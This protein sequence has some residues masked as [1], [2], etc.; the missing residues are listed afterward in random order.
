MLNNFI[1][2]FIE[3]IDYL[4]E[5]IKLIL[6][7]IDPEIQRNT[8]EIR[9]R[10]NR[11]L[12]IK[13]FFKNYYVYNNSQIGLDKNN[14]LYIISEDQIKKSFEN[15]CEYSVYAYQEEINNGFITLQNGS[16]VGIVGTAVSKDKKIINIKNISCLNIR[17]PKN[18]FNVADEL[19]TKTMSKGLSSLLICGAP[20][21]GK[22]TLLKD[23]IRQI[24]LG[25]LGYLYNISVIDERGELFGNQ[26]KN[27]FQNK[28]ENNFDIFDRYPKPTGM[29]IALRTMAPDLIVCD[30]I[31]SKQ[32]TDAI[33]DILNSGV[34]IIA[35][36]HSSN[37]QEIYIKPQI[38]R[39]IVILGS[40]KKPCEIKKII[41]I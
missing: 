6:K 8:Q 31:G 40:N 32:E 14:N 10:A 7:N 11:P 2:N 22:T 18:I 3:T 9:I 12:I 4:E 28:F 29:M 25:R 33:E 5:N 37:E 27:K 38:K 21:S 35:T 13:C 30:E 26:A 19:I 39:Q 16:R 36:A 20:G 15:V 1:N 24:S 17:I 41:L 34:K 23:I